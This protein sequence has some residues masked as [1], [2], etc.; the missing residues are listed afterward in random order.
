MKFTEKEK[1]WKRDMSLIVETKKALK[2][3]SDNLENKLQE[4]QRE[5]QE[6]K[7]ELERGVIPPITEPGEFS[8]IQALAQVN[9]RELEITRLKN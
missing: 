9:M 7:K 2:D 6:E 1:K 4:K 3:R 8:I 5:L